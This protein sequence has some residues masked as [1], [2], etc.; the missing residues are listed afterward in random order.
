M[1]FVFWG[2]FMLLVLHLSSQVCLKE[3]GDKKKKRTACGGGPVVNS[4]PNYFPPNY[5]GRVEGGPTWCLFRLFLTKGEAV[6]RGVKRSMLDSAGANTEKVEAGQKVSR[7]H[8]VSACL[9]TRFSLGR[10]GGR[11]W[12]PPSVNLLLLLPASQSSRVKRHI[13]C[14]RL[15]F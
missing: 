7:S 5:L 3:I 2:F 14:R 10:V 11:P 15:V 6:A 4:F 13:R 8:P 1:F 9:I 12:P